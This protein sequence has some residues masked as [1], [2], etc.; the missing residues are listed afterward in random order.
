MPTRKQRRRTLKSRRHDYEY[1]TVWIDPVSGE[2]V[3]A[4]EDYVP[5]PEADDRTKRN[6]TKPKPKPNARATQKRGDRPVRVPQ[7]PSWRRATK[8]AL[9]IGVVIGV[10][11]YISAAKSGGNPFARALFTAAIYTLA[12][13][14]F[15]YWLDRFMYN[16]WQRRAEQ[17]GQKSP[18]KKR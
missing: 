16:R 15:Q 17:Q 1:E 11:I 8:R 4:P 18:A 13:I 3:E 12:F 9:L 5:E 14:P 7:A 2:E 6:G 10:F